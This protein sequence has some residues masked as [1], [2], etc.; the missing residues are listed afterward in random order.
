M[1]ATR[2]VYVRVHELAEAEGVHDDADVDPE[3]RMAVVVAPDAPDH[4]AIVT[5]ADDTIALRD[6]V[7]GRSEPFFPFG[8]DTRHLPTL[9]CPPRSP[10]FVPRPATLVLR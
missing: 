5:R 3:D 7:G 6:K 10:R 8:H 1:W 9:T 4:D 2:D